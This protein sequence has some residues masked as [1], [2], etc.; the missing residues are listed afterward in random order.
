MAGCW[1]LSALPFDAW[2]TA[3]QV[4]GVEGLKILLDKFRSQGVSAFYQGG[5]AWSM[6]SIVSHYPWYVSNN[7][8]EHYLPGHSFREEPLRALVRSAGIGF[9]SQLFSDCASNWLRVIKTYKQTTT[10][11]ISYR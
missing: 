2:K 8:L 11:Y 3:K 9:V 7:Y 6:S 5:V 10:D 1:R 4:Y